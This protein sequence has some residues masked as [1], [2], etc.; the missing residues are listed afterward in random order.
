MAW[1]TKIIGALLIAIGLYAYMNSTP[2]ENGKVPMTSLIPAFFGMILLICGALSHNP[3]LRKHVM[4]VAAMVGV[5]GAIGGFMPLIRQ[6]SKGHELDPTKLAAASG[7]L[8]S[9]LCAMFVFLCV[10]SFIA[11]KKARLAAIPS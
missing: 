8:M 11:A 9:A 7:L 2:N 1:P 10:R 6:A 4:H 5:L 3:K